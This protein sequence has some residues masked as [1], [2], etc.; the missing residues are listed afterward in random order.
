MGC[1]VPWGELLFGEAI[2]AS[3]TKGKASSVTAITRA[4]IQLDICAP[5]GVPTFMVNSNRE[6]FHL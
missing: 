2:F 4:D 1:R 5:E 6:S 3:Y